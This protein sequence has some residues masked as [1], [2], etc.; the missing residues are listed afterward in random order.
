M[1]T[2]E[3]SII[4]DYFKIT[5]E[6]QTRYGEKIILLM[7]VGAFFE[8][9]GLKNPYTNKHEVTQIDFFSE[10]CHMVI[11]EKSFYFTSSKTIRV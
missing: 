4:L 2:G 3:N 10:S 11:A 1:S 6:Y 7:Q 9:Y 5:K 8:V